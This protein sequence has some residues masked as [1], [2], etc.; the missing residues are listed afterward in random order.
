MFR[1]ANNEKR[2]KTFLFTLI[3]FYFLSNKDFEALA[4]KCHVTK[5]DSKLL[6]NSR[7]ED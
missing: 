4:G 2:A 5:L 3:Y 6:K 7:N 1:A